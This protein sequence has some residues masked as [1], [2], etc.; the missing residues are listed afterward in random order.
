MSELS[1]IANGLLSK[2]AKFVNEQMEIP[3]VSNVRPGV[4][5]TDQY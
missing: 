2:F 5:G 4:E 1:K 3:D